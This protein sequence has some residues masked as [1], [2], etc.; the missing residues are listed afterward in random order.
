MIKENTPLDFALGVDNFRR[1]YTGQVN[2]LT[3]IP[4]LSPIIDD[5]TKPEPFNKR[6]KQLSEAI[7]YAWN[8]VGDIAIRDKRYLETFLTGYANPFVT[9][10]FKLADP[11]LRKNVNIYDPN[12]TPITFPE[13]RIAYTLDY[14][15]S[16]T[17]TSVFDW[18]F[19]DGV[20][21]PKDQYT[22]INTAYGLRCFIKA[23]F[24]KPNT[25]VTV[26]LNRIFNTTKKY[27]TAIN[28]TTPA[29]TFSGL[30]P[31]DTFGTFYDIRYMKVYK[32]NSS[33]IVTIPDKNVK[34]ELDVTGNTLRMDISGY[35]MVAGDKLVVGN[36]IT[37]SVIEKTVDAV[38]IRERIAL[39]FMAGLAFYKSALDF[40]VFL[41]GYKL[42]PHKHF[43][44][45][46]DGDSAMTRSSY[47]V[48]NCDVK[49]N[50]VK[51]FKL[52]IFKNE[53]V[54][55]RDGA[56]IAEQDE[57]DCSF[58]Y[59]RP[60]STSKLPFMTR[61]GHATTGGRYMPNNGVE[62]LQRSV[63]KVD[64]QRNQRKEFTFQS[65]VVRTTDITAVMDH[66]QRNL[67]EFDLALAAVGETQVLEN[68][69]AAN[70]CV[71]DENPLDKTI[72]ETFEQWL[73]WPIQQ[74]QGDISNLDDVMKKRT[75][76]TKTLVLD[77]NSPE[78]LQIQDDL[79]V[80]FNSGLVIDA[81]C[82]MPDYVMTGKNVVL[83]ANEV[84]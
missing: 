14:T 82:Y 8:A 9:Q 79:V 42:I 61:I 28:V 44:V 38:T 59:V 21:A 60:V 27:M 1:E 63:L 68:Y 29:S 52:Q 19:I 17:F 51:E 18:V 49:V 6:F 84:I 40:D 10:S 54:G 33:G 25:E 81:N 23:Q 67:S 43:S 31:V 47:L 30:F 48:L 22:I 62:A 4:P 41:D 32:E 58:L 16:V 20:L 2:I 55:Y 78:A 53:S 64:R 11:S 35:P 50:I 26:V 24:I 83:D 57:L 45:I 72:E 15:G 73:T 7:K 77:A 5:L 36:C 34:F 12:G 46:E 66:C 56:D 74:S 69:R 75:D 37:P 71:D 76:K 80:F 3:R 13:D 39:S 65:R 70:P